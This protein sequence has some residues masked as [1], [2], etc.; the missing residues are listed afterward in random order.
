MDETDN[1]QQ[2]L[3][4]LMADFKAMLADG[5]R[6]LDTAEQEGDDALGQWRA[7]VSERVDE[8]QAHLQQA[9]QAIAAQTRAAANVAGAYV[10]ANPWKSVLVVGGL[11]ALLG[12]L[13]G[14][15]QS[16]ER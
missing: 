14:R 9:E 4:R 11:A 16:S 15:V 8:V 1:A 5:E 6:L 13:A 3:S 7:A 2:A 12:Y 10:R